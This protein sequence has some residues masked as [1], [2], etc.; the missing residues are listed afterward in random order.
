M[1]SPE[2]P[3]PRRRSPVWIL[4]LMLLVFVAPIVL[5]WWMY[6]YTQLGR[7][8]GAY[9][10]GELVRPPRQLPDMPLE[11]PLAPARSQRLHGKWSLVYLA[12]GTCDDR[13]E[14]R[15]YMMRQI[16]LAMGRD[17]ERLQRVLLLFEPARN[18]VPGWPPYRGQLVAQVEHGQADALAAIFTMTDADRP[19][20][21]GRLY[22]ID[23]LG[24]LMMSYPPGTD[25]TGI[26]KDLER[27]FKYSGIG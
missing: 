24:N 21:A 17:A 15:F 6:N 9:S 1:H 4:G 23:P 12:R 27:L 25:P 20:D 10:H 2:P 26:I 7:D 5:S 16:R 22:I 3:G 18:A 19:L 14:Q 13:C 8:G 11:D